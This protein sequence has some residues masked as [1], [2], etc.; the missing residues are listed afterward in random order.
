MAVPECGPEAPAI[1]RGVSVAGYAAAVSTQERRFVAV[2]VDA[3]ELLRP[4][5]DLVRLVEGAGHVDV[6][7]AVDDIPIGPPAS[8]GVLAGCDAGPDGPVDDDTATGGDEFRASVMTLGLPELYVHRLGLAGPLAASS[9]DD[10]VAGLSELVG[11]DP[12]P[13][14]YLLAPAIGSDDQARLVVDRAVQRIAQVY[15]IPLMRYRC[16]ELTMVA[17]P[18]VP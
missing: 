12:E 17:E 8:L 3:V 18:L 9:E 16:H 11:F 15:G 1:P 14:V 13:G 7:V 6:L 4:G 5:S 2:T 10:L